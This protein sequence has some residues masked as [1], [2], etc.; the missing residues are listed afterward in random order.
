MNNFNSGPPMAG[1]PPYNG[2][3][4]MNQQQSGFMHSQHAA[5]AGLA[6]LGGHSCLPLEI[7]AREPDF[8]VHLFAMLDVNATEN[9]TAISKQ[10]GVKLS[11]LPIMCLAQGA[12]SASKRQSS[13]LHVHS[14]QGI[15]PN[16]LFTL[17]PFGELMMVESIESDQTVT[18]IR[19]MGDSVQPCAIPA[20]SYLIYAGNAFEEASLRPLPTWG[21]TTGFSIQTH[22]SRTSWA[23]SGTQRAIMNADSGTHG[24]VHGSYK[25]AAMALAQA[26]ESAMLFSQRSSTVY[27][28][29]PMRTM[30]GY[31][32]YLHL[33]APQNIVSVVGGM[34]YEDL[35]GLFNSF[36]GPATASYSTKRIIYGDAQFCATISRIGR[37]YTD[38]RME[39]GSDA[40]GKRFNAFLTD[41][42]SFH[43]Y[44]HEMLD[45]MGDGSGVGMII[46][47]KT[48]KL[49]YLKGRKSIHQSYNFD[50]EGK[51]HSHSADNGID[52][53]GGSFISEFMLI[54]E[55]PAA[56]GV[57]FNLN[58]AMCDEMCNRSTVK[59]FIDRRGDVTS[60]DAANV[61][62]TE[63]VDDTTGDTV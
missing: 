16:M 41:N 1:I 32:E 8:P 7:L 48:L 58:S 14:T 25:D 43:V 15:I 28:G 57:I 63:I 9:L 29:M 33:S 3:Y 50:T 10:F 31:R 34:N 19:G 11:S 24:S 60:P 42:L 20:E 54:N 53:G 2:Q 39:S 59:V 62:V 55:N 45:I 12:P 21:S 13:T 18:V 26:I 30:T 52:A 27:N 36:K 5:G 46:D 17:I 61:E 4:A 23:L 37:N 35:N 56:G 38:I 47:P 22:I 51:M 40:F 6:N 44:H 49:E